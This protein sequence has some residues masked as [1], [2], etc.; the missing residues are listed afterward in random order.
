MITLLKKFFIDNWQRKLLALILAMIIWIVVN[1]YMSLS[2]TIRNVSIKVK[3]IPKGKTVEGVQSD[4]TLQKKISINV[5]GNKDI[6]QSL[7]SKDVEIVLDASRTKGRWNA[8]ITKDHLVFL[9]QHID[10]RSIKQVSAQNIELKTVP[11]ISEKVPVFVSKPIGDPPRGY[12]FLDIIPYRLFL[13]ITG[14]E[15]EVKKLKQ[16]GVKLTFNLDRISRDDLDR[17]QDEREIDQDGVSYLVPDHLKK[18]HIPSL[19]KYPFE[20]DDVRADDLKINFVKQKLLKIASPIPVSV[21]FSHKLTRKQHQKKYLLQ[22]N[23][24]LQLKNGIH[25][26]NTQLYAKGISPLFAEIVKDMIQIVVTITPDG[27][28]TS[29]NVQVL[30]PHIL[31]DRYVAEKLI[32]SKLPS[33]FHNDTDY[34]EEYFRN[35][36]RKYLNTLRL[37]TANN[38]KLSLDIRIIDDKITL[39]PKNML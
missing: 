27:R 7:Q 19:S 20:I 5:L 34:R 13:N 39:K 9:N 28:K 35:R 4:G 29:W 11:M 22:P 33:S 25:I 15:T 37:F 36:F 31:E 30:H 17:L 38:E 16:E 2:T 6:I 8:A 23:Q 26:I 21:F 12:K 3:N 10:A 24:F 18:I 14:P 1:H 32:R